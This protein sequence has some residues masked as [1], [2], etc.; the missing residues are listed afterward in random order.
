MLTELSVVEQRY[1][2]VREVLEGAKVTDVA[3]RPVHVLRCG[4]IQSLTAQPWARSLAYM[5]NPTPASIAPAIH[6]ITEGQRLSTTSCVR[7]NVAS[8]MFSAHRTTSTGRPTLLQAM[9]SA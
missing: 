9:P 1:L 2:A 3:T 5:A 4:H 7:R 6:A 8:A